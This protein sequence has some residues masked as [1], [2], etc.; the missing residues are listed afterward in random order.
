MILVKNDYITIEKN[1]FMTESMRIAYDK[2][3]NIDKLG[4][5]NTLVYSFIEDN[6]IPKYGINTLVLSLFTTKFE[7]LQI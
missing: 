6:T 4:E 7:T 2:K 5:I 1:D 3:F